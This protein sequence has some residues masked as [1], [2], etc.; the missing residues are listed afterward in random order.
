MSSGGHVADM[1]RRYKQDREL[2]TLRRERARD[3]KNRQMQ[4]KKTS[5]DYSDITAEERMRVRGNLK[6][7]EQQEQRHLS[8][9]S[10]LILSILMVIALLLL[11]LFK[12]IG[13]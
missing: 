4:I 7:R 6:K 2:R 13:I 8:R 11:G 1:V 9:N 5:S 3:A 10:L 12:V